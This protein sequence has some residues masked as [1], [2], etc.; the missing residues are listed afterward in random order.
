MAAKQPPLSP[1]AL[2]GSGWWD[3]VKPSS[4]EIVVIRHDQ[5]ILLFYASVG[6][7]ASDWPSFA[8]DPIASIAS[9]R[10]GCSHYH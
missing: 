1:P 9:K 3:S 10:I 7:G 8:F 6:A 2:T 5:A 4:T